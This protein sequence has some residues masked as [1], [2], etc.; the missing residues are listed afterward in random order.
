[1]RLVHAQRTY[2]LE[3]IRQDFPILGQPMRGKPLVYL[4]NGAT[5]LKPQQ[6][7]DAEIEYLRDISANIHRGVYELSERATLLFDESRE[8]IKRFI[9]APEDG[10]AIFTKSS[11]EAS[12]LVAFGWGRKFLKPGDEIVTSELE[13]HAN[14]IP[15]QEVAKQTGAE[16]RFVELGP[17]GEITA[18][19]VAAALTERTSVVALTGMSNVTG[20]MPPIAEIAGLVHERGAILV[21]DGAQLVSHYPVNVRALDLDFLTFSGHKM[22]GPTGVGVLYGRK[23]LL[24]EM[25]PLLYGGDMIVRVFKDRASYKGAPDKFE[26]GTPNISGAIALGAA[27]D[28]LESIGMEAIAEHEEHVLDYA[29]E[30]LSSLDDVTLY[31]PANV[32]QR[33]GILSFNVGDVHPHDVGTILDGEGVAVRTGFHC[34]QP[35]MRYLGIHGTVRASFYLYNRR[36]DVDRLVDAIAR[37]KDVFS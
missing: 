2:D 8:K 29:V 33:G 34:A 1:M 25:D 17:A 26:T 16:L 15:W 22:C 14:L 10:E 31:G 5:A 4:D 30:R 28:Y 13:H 6:V 23:S 20:F 27:V 11:T 9:G 7:I 36:E 37:V 19:A 12:N 21:V 24:E 35:F 3:K 18:E 32:R